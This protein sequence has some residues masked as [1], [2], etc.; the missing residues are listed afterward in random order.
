MDSKFGWSLQMPGSVT[1]RSLNCFL[2]TYFRSFKLLLKRY[3]RVRKDY[4]L[5][6]QFLNNDKIHPIVQKRDLC[7]LK[8]RYELQ[9]S[10]PQ[11]VLQRNSKRKLAWRF[12]QTILTIWYHLD[13]KKK[14]VV[15]VLRVSG[16]EASYWVHSL[17][18]SYWVDSADWL[19]HYYLNTIIS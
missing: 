9:S 12:V 4:C 3:A 16:I 19:I 6:C 8:T 2:H 1:P 7:R 18:C 14:I 11:F 5:T 10:K 13:L 17:D 15:L